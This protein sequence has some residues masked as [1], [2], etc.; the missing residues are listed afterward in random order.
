MK[1]TFQLTTS[2]PEAYLAILRVLDAAADDGKLDFKYTIRPDLLSLQAIAEHE[3][4]GAGIDVSWPT[5]RRAIKGRI[6][7]E[8]G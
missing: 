2:T 7:Y 4:R 3:L 8:R 6:P 5:V 1:L